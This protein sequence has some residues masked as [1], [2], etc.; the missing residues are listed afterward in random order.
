VIPEGELGEGVGAGAGLLSEDGGRGRGRGEADDGAAGGGPRGGERGHGG[1]LAGP[2]GGDRQ[3]YPPSGGG[4]L[5]D[6]VGLGGVEGDAVGDRL[7]QGYLDVLGAH[8]AA[9]ELV[10]GLDDER[11]VG[12]DLRGGEQPAAGDLVDADAIGAA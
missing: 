4:H 1:G 11:L 10:G 7:Q 2:G 9:A 6:Q 5:A 12:Q 8:Y 3:L